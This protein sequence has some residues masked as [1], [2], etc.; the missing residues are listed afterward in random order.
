MKKI[1]FF[2]IDGTLVDFYGRIPE[3]ALAAIRAL[4]EN[5]HLAVIS[6]GRSRGFIR[7]PRLMAVPFDGIVSGLGTRIEYKDKVIEEYLFSREDA[8]YAVEVS[9]K[10]KFPVILEGPRYLYLDPEDF[11]EDMYV[12]RVRDAMQEDLL[13]IR[14]HWG[15]WEMN[16]YSC[17]V[18]HETEKACLAAYEE[19]FD[20]LRHNADV[21]EIDDV[22]WGLWFLDVNDNPERYEG[23]TVKFIA[24]KIADDDI[25]Y[26]VTQPG[27]SPADSFKADCDELGISEAFERLNYCF[28]QICRDGEEV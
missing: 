16:K 20:L 6:S 7:D 28:V 14:D 25:E 27:I 15:E 12:K 2:D 23:K 21:I 8:L 11:A 19:R 9:K 26:T 13:T 4:R 10:Y 3:S 24:R 22:D 1:V 17:A 5:G 18:N